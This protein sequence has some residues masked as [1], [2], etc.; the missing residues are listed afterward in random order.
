[1][2]VE[3]KNGET[4]NGHLVNCDVNIYKYILKKKKKKKKK[5]KRL[6]YY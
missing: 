1:M 6:I 4:Y 3:L 5:K 2:Q